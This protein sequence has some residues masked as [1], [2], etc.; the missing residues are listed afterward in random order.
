MEMAEGSL[1]VPA[2]MGKGQVGRACPPLRCS[3]RDR[4][5]D[6][7][8]GPGHAEVELRVLRTRLPVLSLLRG[9]AAR[10][11]RLDAV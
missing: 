10:D 7:A 1:V 5:G 11:Q 4:A 6:P 2:G 8:V 9:G 3:A